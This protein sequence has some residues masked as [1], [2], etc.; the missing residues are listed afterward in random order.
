MMR[1]RAKL[2]K[3]EDAVVRTTQ[4]YESA[5]AQNSVAEEEIRALENHALGVFQE[6][7]VLQSQLHVGRGRGNAE[8]GVHLHRTS[9][10]EAELAEASEIETELRENVHRA[11]EDFSAE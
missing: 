6:C 7:E 9:E 2:E 8:I 11:S 3:A 4:T 10:L 1:L 5:P